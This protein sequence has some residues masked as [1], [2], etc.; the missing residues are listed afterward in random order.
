[1]TLTE[2][3]IHRYLPYRL[4]E[5]STEYMQRVWHANRG[6]WLL[7]D[8]WSC[9]TLGLACVLMSR[10]ISPELVLSPDFW[11]SNHYWSGPYY[12]IWLFTYCTRFPWNICNGCGMPTEDATS[13]R[14]PGP[15][16]FGICICSS[17]R[18]HTTYLWRL[19]NMTFTDIYLTD[20]ERFQQNICNGCGMPTGDADSSGHLVLSHFGT[21]MC[22][23]V[24]TNLSWTCLVSGLL[25][26][27]HPS[28]L[29]FCLIIIKVF[30]YGVNTTY[31][32]PYATQTVKVWILI[33]QKT[34]KIVKL[35]GAINKHKHWKLTKI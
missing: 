22:S 8:T 3:D 16:P 30:N 9:P 6:R 17:K 20:L 29:L 33:N 26:F 12:R 34:K 19:P 31:N 2:Y 21:C 13:L 7:R 1:M 18:N 27:E 14:T 15:I 4:G 24:E 28:V 10:P 25:N 32:V 5:V 23:N 35:C 11:I